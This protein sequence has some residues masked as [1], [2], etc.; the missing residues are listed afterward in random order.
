MNKRQMVFAMLLL[1]A[2]CAH[3]NMTSKV[4]P[5]YTFTAPRLLV[6]EQ[7]SED[8]IQKGFEAS[9]PN[10]MGSCGVTTI[11]N[12][13]PPLHMIPKMSVTH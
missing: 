11:D 3:T 12:I 8:P 7:L 10:L 4:Q 1:C 9:F 2:N 13:M 5:G 6:L